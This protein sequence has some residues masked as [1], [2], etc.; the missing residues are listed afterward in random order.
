MMNIWWKDDGDDPQALVELE[1]VWNSWLPFRGDG[2]H[3]HEWLTATCNQIGC[4]LLIWVAS[5]SWDEIQQ[6]LAVAVTPWKQISFSFITTQT[7]QLV[8]RSGRPYAAVIVSSLYVTWLDG[9]EDDNSAELLLKCL[10]CSLCLEQLC[11]SVRLTR[12]FF[13]LQSGFLMWLQS[14]TQHPPARGCCYIRSNRTTMSLEW[15]VRMRSLLNTHVG[16]PQK[17]NGA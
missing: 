14:V 12:D 8:T 11:G 4:R 17:L 9:E 10:A 1:N 6:S 3:F 7:E 13:H 15:R 16:E 5:K 2:F